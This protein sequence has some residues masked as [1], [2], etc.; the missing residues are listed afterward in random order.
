MSE[1]GNYSSVQLDR[2]LNRRAVQKIA[3][4]FTENTTIDPD[5]L[6]SNSALIR[7]VLEQRLPQ[8]EKEYDHHSSLAGVANME[9]E[10]LKEMADDLRSYIATGWE[11]R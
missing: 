4:R 3:K 9:M 2:E 5:E 1:L 7:S 8:L 6:L 11:Y 10:S